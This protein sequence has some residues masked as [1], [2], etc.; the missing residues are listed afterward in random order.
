MRQRPWTRRVAAAAVLF[1]L[2]GCTAGIRYAAVDSVAAAK[3]RPHSSYYCYDCHGYRYFDPYYDWCAGYGFRY[4]WSGH[5]EV[6]GLYRARYLEIRETHP[7]YGRYRY[8]AGYRE[9]RRYRHPPSYEGWQE[10]IE[11]RTGGREK[12]REQNPPVPVYDGRL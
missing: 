7:E 2:A 4:R 12:V 3:A 10:G 6:T 8:R 11:E 9:N 5:P 1:A